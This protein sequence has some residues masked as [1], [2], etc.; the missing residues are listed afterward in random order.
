MELIRVVVGERGPAVVELI[1]VVVRAAGSSTVTSCL[2]A[3]ACK[4]H[5]A[6]FFGYRWWSVMAVPLV[7]VHA[8]WLGH[9]LVHLNYE[10]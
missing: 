7:V 9:D 4:Q 8:A 10:H 2:Y 6:A 3:A 5:S 1:Q